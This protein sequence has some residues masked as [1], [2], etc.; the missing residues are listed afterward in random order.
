MNRL[1]S[2]KTGNGAQNFAFL[3]SKRGPDLDPGF[4]AMQEQILD[5]TEAVRHYLMKRCAGVGLT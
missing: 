1:Q 4:T 2:Q 5:E 3:E